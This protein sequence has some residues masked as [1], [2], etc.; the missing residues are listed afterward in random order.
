MATA[1]PHVGDIGTDLRFKILDESFGAADGAIVDVSSATTIQIKFRKPDGEVV[2]V[3]GA[4]VTDGTDGLIKYT[5]VAAS[6]LDEA[7][8]WSAQVRV[9]LGSG[10]W[11]TAH[12]AFTVEANLA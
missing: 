3:T 6:F 2:T 7:G 11:H 9:V 12:G 10:D 8:P 1:F 5:T 4:L